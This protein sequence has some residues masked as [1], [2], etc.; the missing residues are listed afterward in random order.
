M[1]SPYYADD[2][3][4]LYLG[5]MEEI[6][7]ALALTA[8]AVVT[9][10]PYGDTKLSWDRWVD[11][12]PALAAAVSTTMWCFGS[13]RMFL[14]HIDEFADAGWKFSQ[15]IVWEKHNGSSLAADR[16]KRVHEHAL[17]FYRGH[18]SDQ[19]HVVPTTADAIK[20]TLRRK[21]LPSTHVGARGASTYV[22]EDGGPRLM[23]SVIAVRSMHGRGVHPTEKPAGILQPLIEYAVPP[24]GVLLD[25]FAGSGSALATAKAIGR[26][27]IGIEG[28]EQYAEAIA[29]R[30]CQDPLDF[31]VA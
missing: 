18:W 16:F 22:S 20:L 1:P 11:G 7:P 12:W 4:Q 19:H 10:P 29:K 30:L 25:P 14:G 8:D 31:E 17:H 23:R 3:C 27:A 28:D 26:R 2:R 24:G 5:K 13:M 15:D 9:D 21:G 6:L